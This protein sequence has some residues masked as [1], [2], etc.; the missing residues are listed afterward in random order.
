[1]RDRAL[2]PE[3]SAPKRDPVRPLTEYFD[4]D[5]EADF[6]DGED[7]EGIAR[8]RPSEPSTSIEWSSGW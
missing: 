7:G 6:D 1:M 5:D 4:D 8:P 2:P 3:P